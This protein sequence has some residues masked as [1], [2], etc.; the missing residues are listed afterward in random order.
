ME[1]NYI[2]RLINSR[3]T[4][5]VIVSNGFQLRGRIVDQSDKAIILKG[6]DRVE[7]LIYKNMISTIEPCAE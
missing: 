4:V 6:G 2:N 3:A 1:Q 5:R 7:K